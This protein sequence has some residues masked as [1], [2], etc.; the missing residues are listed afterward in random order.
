MKNNSDFKFDLMVGRTYEERLGHIL[1]NKKIEVKTDFMAHTTGNIAVEYM[2]R[3]K[4]SGIATTH[5]D[6]YAYII[7]R[8]SCK[9]IVLLMS[10]SELKKMSRLY[11][12]QGK[13]K[14]MGDSNQS[15][16]VLIPLVNLFKLSQDGEAK[17]DEC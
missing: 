14:A 10:V 5:A 7:P 3:G 9:E 6:Y 4:P 17:E 11:Y 12:K 16:A 13:I 15:L 1:D 8:A 2:C